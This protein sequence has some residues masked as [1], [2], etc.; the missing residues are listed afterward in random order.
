M[1]RF[2]LKNTF[3]KIYI[4]HF[5]TNIFIKKS[6]QNYALETVSL[7]VIYFLHGGSM[8][9]TLCL[10]ATLGCFVHFINLDIRSFCAEQKIQVALLTC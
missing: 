2:V 5:S 6:N 10:V 7:N 3:I 1:I 4:Y 8:Y 9:I